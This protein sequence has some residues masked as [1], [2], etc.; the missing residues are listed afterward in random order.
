MNKKTKKI[1]IKSHLKL[2]NINKLKI[3]QK[4][5][6][7]GFLK[8]RDMIGIL[9]TGYGKSLTYILPHLMKNINV[10]VISPLLSLMEDQYNKLIN[11]NINCLLFNSNHKKELYSVNGI[12]K[13]ENIKN[14]LEK[15]ILYFSPESLFNYAGF[16]KELISNNNVGLFA[17]DESHC[18]CTWSDFRNDYK[19]LKFI[20]DWICSYQKKIPILALTATATLSIQ[21]DIIKSLKLINPLIIKESVYK[22]NLIIKINKKYS[23][24]DTMASIHGILTKHNMKTIIYAKTRKDTEKIAERLNWMNIKCHYFHAGLNN[25][26]RLKIQEDFHNNKFKVIIATIAFGMGVDIKDIHCIIHYGISKDI[27]SYVQEIGRGGRDGTNVYCYL[28]W[29]KKDFSTNQY[30]IS[31]IKDEILREKQLQKS[32]SLEKFIHTSKCRMGFICTYFGCEFIKCKKCDNCNKTMVDSSI[33]DFLVSNNGV[34][35]K[36][37]FVTNEEKRF[38]LQV[39]REL[40]YGLGLTMLTLILYGSKSKKI[41][42]K[43]KNLESYGKMKYCKQ[44]EIKDKIKK[45]LYNDYLKICNIDNGKAHYYK[46]SKKGT[47][48]INNL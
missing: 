42:Q 12:K 1:K 17:I 43:L 44:N 29:S 19:N 10:I 47:N 41:N 4:E 33:M 5:L 21:K 26:K 13:L 14:G 35:K 36:E 20:K 30:F 6:I 39:Y 48:F 34:R 40:N 18:I 24:S 38:I 9:P 37:I 16:I 25:K 31:N 46:L 11:L 7:N 22:K 2:F 3:K 28:Y 8:K 15:Y 23:F 32:F 45:I 27:E